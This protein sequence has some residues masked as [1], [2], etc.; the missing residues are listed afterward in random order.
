VNLP[1]LLPVSLVLFAI[2]LP[3]RAVDYFWDGADSTA[4]ADG[5]SGTWDTGLASNWD[6]LAEAGTDASWVNGYVPRFGGLPGAV[7]VGAGGVVV[8]GLSFDTG[9]YLVQDGTIA[10]NA[11]STIASNADA[12]VS[13]TLA[14]SG[15]QYITTSGAGKLTLSGTASLS[16]FY[17][18]SNVDITGSFSTNNKFIVQGGILTWSGSGAVGGSADYVGVADSISGTL[19]VTAG[20]LVLNPSGSFFAGNGS[21]AN[22]GTVN[23]S[24]GT[25]AVG[26]NSPVY[27]GAG[28]NGN[29]SGTGSVI[30]SGTGTFT[31]GST[32]GIL[33]LGGQSGGNGTINLES[34]GTFA[35]ARTL[36]KGTSGTSTATAAINFN[37]GTLRANGNNGD[38][39]WKNITANVQAGGAIIDS[40]GFNVSI[41]Q[42]FTNSGGTD[43]GLTKVGAGELSLIDVASTSSTFNGGV[44]V[45]GGTLLAAGDRSFGAVPGAFT[46]SNITLDGGAIKNTNVNLTLG[47]NRG[48]YLGNNG[49]NIAVWGG[50]VF[51]VPGTISGPGNLSKVD[52]GTLVLDGGGSYTGTTT[53][54]GGTL[55]VNGSLTSAITIKSAATLNGNGSTAG[56]LAVEAG[57]FL[58][59]GNGVGT[60]SAADTTLAGTYAAQVDA[61]SADLLSVTGS[62][63][64]TGATLAISTL[65][66]P[67]AGSYVIAR[68]TTTLT[69]EFSIVTGMPSG[70]S[71]RYD[72][73]NR[74]VLLVTQGG[75]GAWA[76]QNGL[77]GNPAEDFDKDG[78]ADAV[79]YVLGNSPTAASTGGP[80]LSVSGGNMVFTFV[81][82]HASLTPDVAV[83]V[84]VGMLLTGWPV[85]YNVGTTTATSDPGI[86]VTNNGP[87][88]TITLTLAQI[89]DT[90]KF[91]RLK[92]IVTP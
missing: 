73:A 8:G 36:S 26:N 3:L 42:A 31:T 69:G 77:S 48:I 9:G 47:S 79:E 72:V 82:D 90:R 43:G 20:S 4:N 28:F 86:T 70:Y 14:M 64:L 83:N 25:L 60:F 7:T 2:A 76:G 23:V 91:A 35:T 58:A 62:L 81:R 85:V 75:F 51:T 30:V 61:A 13:S 18:L 38:W 49:G 87:N 34:G 10:F 66:G 55:Q 88:D 53:A 45:K 74:R 5:G 39:I 46:A 21:T 17:V 37:G 27:V 52:V 89:P 56:T 40:N 12:T 50:R 32:S 1:R 68:Y 71:L 16:Q 15:G 33:R 80:S 29:N 44:M 6:T 92:V 57:G 11:N 59:P 54:N 19:N 41:L 22:I 65:A 63:N 24:A 67:A 78:L 84:E